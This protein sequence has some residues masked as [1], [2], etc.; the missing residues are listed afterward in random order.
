MGSQ[1]QRDPES[2][3]STVSSGSRRASIIVD[4]RNDAGYPARSYMRIVRR[5]PR[6]QVYLPDDLY[7]AV[8]TRGLAASELLQ[9][10]VRVELRRR[11]LLEATDE[12]LAELLI[13]VGEPGP[14]ETVRA[15]A[16][17]RRLSRRADRAAG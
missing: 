5:M 9:D 17:A 14:E 6:M 8:K 3:D 7:E 10:A 12:Y 15:Q 13:E 16:I 4:P 2:F 11:Q 1:R